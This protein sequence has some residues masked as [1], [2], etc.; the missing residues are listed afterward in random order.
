MPEPRPSTPLS[1]ADRREAAREQ[2]RLAR[3]K[4]LRQERLRRWLIPSG[5][6]V[7]VLAVVAVIVLVVSMSAPAPQTAAGPKNMI[8]DGILFTGVDGKV[9]ATSTAA[10]PAKGTPTPHSPD[11]EGDVPHIVEYIDFACPYCGKFESTNAATIQTL[12]AAG[13]VTLEVRPV[14]ILDRSFLGTRYPSRAMNAAGCVANFS[15]NDFLTVVTAF[16]A[17]RPQEQTAGLTNAQIVR[18]VRNA[19]VSNNDIE[20][21]ISGESYRSWVSA[22][23]ARFLADPA[24]VNPAGQIGTPTVFVNGQMFSGS[25]S[26]PGAFDNFLAQATS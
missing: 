4:Q 22:A 12:V 17:N 8:S 16:Y 21:C 9:V 2:A 5:V 14:A 10:I 24:N 7:V 1:K 18:L 3:E 23:T 19:G 13:K 20:K 25:V 11:S 15:P 26:D 6:T